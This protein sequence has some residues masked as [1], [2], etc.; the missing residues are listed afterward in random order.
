MSP[1]DAQD[2]LCLIMNKGQPGWWVRGYMLG[3]Q[4]LRNQKTWV[5]IKAVSLLDGNGLGQ[6]IFLW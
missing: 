4:A 5:Q 6:T 3:G 1:A 2:K